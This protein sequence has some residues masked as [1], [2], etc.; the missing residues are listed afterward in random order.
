M[1]LIR[2]IRELLYFQGYTIQGAR[3]QLQELKQGV[4][5]STRVKVADEALAASVIAA[6][7]KP[8]HQAID[9]MLNDLE[10]IAQLL[11]QDA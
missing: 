1:Q 2:R 9:E 10:Q 8:L 3:V 7:S 11:S 5:Q 4:T 6:G